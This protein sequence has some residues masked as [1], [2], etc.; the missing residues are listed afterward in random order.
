MNSIT[1]KLR[2]WYVRL[3]KHYRIYRV[4][5][6]RLLSLRNAWHLTWM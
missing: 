6:G 5:Q 2:P 1:L 4:Y 3:R